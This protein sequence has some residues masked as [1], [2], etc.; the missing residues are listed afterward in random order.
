MNSFASRSRIG[1]AAV[2]SYPVIP[3]DAPRVLFISAADSC[4]AAGH[5]QDLR[6]A[7]LCGCWPLSAISGLSVQNFDRAQLMYPPPEGYLESALGAARESDVRAVK[8]G[9]LF[10][11]ES[12]QTVAAHIDAFAHI[13]WDP[14]FAPSAGPAFYSP[15][16][17]TFF[18]ER[19]LR[20]IT[21]CTPNR[22]ELE[23]LAG[24]SFAKAADAIEW[25]A[26]F[27]GRPAFLIKGGHFGDGQHT[28]HDYLVC[29]GVHEFTHARKVFGYFRA[30]GCLLSSLIACNL[31]KG[32]DM[33]DATASSIG[34]L[35]GYYSQINSTVSR[36][37]DV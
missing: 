22:Q 35:D 11:L 14:V 4:G 36:I 27:E 26:S 13:V 29:N 1:R 8:V 23:T 9:A 28:L 37:P 21:L 18:R 20:Q 10:S 33:A 16:M 7:A 15:G 17:I 12:L 30:S 2:V 31:A 25:A 19:L 24:R 3:C 34:I 5:D 6:A 32:G